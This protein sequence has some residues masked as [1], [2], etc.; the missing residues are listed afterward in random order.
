MVLETCVAGKLSSDAAA[1]KPWRCSTPCGSHQQQQ[2]QQ[3]QRV[4]ASLH[5]SDLHQPHQPSLTSLYS[6]VSLGSQAPPMSDYAAAG[7]GAGGLLDSKPAI[8]AASMF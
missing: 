8:I 5:A 7:A 3:Q 2:Q 4:A 6:G 1:C